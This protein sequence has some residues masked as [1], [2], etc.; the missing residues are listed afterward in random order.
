MTPS[1]RAIPVHPEVRHDP[2][3]VR[4]SMVAFTAA[5]ILI[6]GAILMAVLWGLLQFLWVTRVPA[7]ALYRVPQAPKAPVF[8]SQASAELAVI[9]RAEDA[10]LQRYEWT[11]RAAQRVRV[12]IE[13]AMEIVVQQGLPEFS[14]EHGGAH[15]GKHH[16]GGRH[17]NPAEAIDA[18]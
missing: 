5:G 15:S 18:R 7:R 10:R 17:G 14:A 13:R 1:Q 6:S 16:H 4:W 12:P 9:R 11:D 2:H 3:D 8:E